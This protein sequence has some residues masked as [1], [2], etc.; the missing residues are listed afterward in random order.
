MTIRRALIP[1]AA[2]AFLAAAT[3]A[4]Q[5]AQPKKITFKDKAGQF[6]I[7]NINSY[8]ADIDIQNRGPFT[9][10]GKGSPLRGFASKQG[11]NF[12]ASAVDAILRPVGESY[13]FDRAQLT[14]GVSVD[15]KEGA[16]SQNLKTSRLTITD[17]DAEG[18]IEVPG[19]F[20]FARAEGAQRLNAKAGSGTFSF[21]SLRSPNTELKTATMRGGVTLNQSGPKGTADLQSP[22]VTL[23]VPQSGYRVSM[24]SAFTV[25]ATDKS[26][27][28]ADMS[29]KG[30]S[31]TM[32]LSKDGGGIT[33]TL[34]GAD[35]AGPITLTLDSVSPEGE[36]SAYRATGQ[37]M[38][39]DAA[40][41]TLVLTGSVDYTIKVVKPEESPMEIEAQAGF[42][43]LTLDADGKVTSFKSGTGTAN[44]KTGDGFA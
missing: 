43:R 12:Q 15:Q 28:T 35:I 38:S 2:V 30:S 7:E 9:F 17:S 40:T 27:G 26:N 1:I 33:E 3:A 20:T 25:N 16:V 5:Q 11:L 21:S 19:S 6:R 31:G 22:S 10:E 39:Y 34:R 44:L 36:V 37:K 8:L 18:K 23:T 42:V 24:P 4:P 13:V 32:S 41:R 14:G 29:L